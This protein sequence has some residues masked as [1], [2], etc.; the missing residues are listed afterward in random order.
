[1]GGENAYMG[2]L[3]KLESGD[4]YP[5]PS[6]PIKWR[7]FFYIAAEEMPNSATV[8]LERKA[9]FEELILS[10]FPAHLWGGILVNFT[11]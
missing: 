4:Y 10:I 1:M 11:E 8:P 9:E 5:I 2:A 6:D 7:G 3:V